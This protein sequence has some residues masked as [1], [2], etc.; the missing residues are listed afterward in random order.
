[1]PRLR[2]PH[3]PHHVHLPIPR[4]V[5]E[6]VAWVRAH[7]LQALTVAGNREHPQT[8]GTFRAACHDLRAFFDACGSALLSLHR[9][10]S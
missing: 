10:P 5:A 9:M 7:S 8:A 1:M 3:A 4:A 2:S 6:V